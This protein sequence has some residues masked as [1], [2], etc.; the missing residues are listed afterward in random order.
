MEFPVELTSQLKAGDNV[1]KF[2]PLDKGWVALTE[3][4]ILYS[5]YVLSD[6]QV[7]VRE[8]GNL[9]LSKISSMAVREISTGGC[10]GKKKTVLALNLQGAIYNVVIGNNVASARVF[11][12]EFNSRTD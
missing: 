6:S 9:P 3:S 4:R 8:A 10:M 11:V 7:A 2:L 5:A 12:S 1:L